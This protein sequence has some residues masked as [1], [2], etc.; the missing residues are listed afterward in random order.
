MMRTL[1]TLPRVSLALGLAVVCFGGAPAKADPF[2]IM[3]G[4]NDGY[5]FGV[6]DNGTAVWPGAGS[7]GSLYDGRSAGEA[8]ATDGA[9]F[10]DVYSA[11]DPGNGP[12]TTS[13]GDVIFNLPGTLTSATLQVDMG[14]FQATTFGPI[15]VSFNGVAQPGLFDFEDG[16]QATQVRDFVLSA[17]DLAAAN[18][19]GQFIVTLDRAGSVDFIAFDYFKL[20]GEFTPAVPEPSS[21]LMLGTGALGLL[22]G[23]ARRRRTKGPAI[24]A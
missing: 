14:D 4:D 19:A 1:K 7:S 13:F 18:A 22:G 11:I 10:T 24:P 9:Q 15:S 21:L 20:S 3:I 5:G 8:A 16:F 6:P 12:N 2:S 23:Y 17:A